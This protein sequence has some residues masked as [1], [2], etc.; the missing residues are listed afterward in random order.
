MQDQDVR[1]Y[2]FPSEFSEQLLYLEYNG[3]MRIMIMIIIIMMMMT[4]MMTMMMMI[5]T[6]TM[7][8]IMMKVMIMILMMMIVSQ[9][10]S[11]RF[12]KLEN[13]LNHRANLSTTMSPCS[14]VKGNAKNYFFPFLYE[15]T[16]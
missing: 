16:A 13:N 9:N 8:M 7:M 14:V 6:T 15:K 12:Q 4:M 5:M 2:I 1:V 10:F 11:P 3:G